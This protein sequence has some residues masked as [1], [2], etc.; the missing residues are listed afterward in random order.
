VR[1]I[2]HHAEGLVEDVTFALRF[3]LRPVKRRLLP[4]SG[5]ADEARRGER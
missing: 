4:A 1:W 3:A 5:A 2:G